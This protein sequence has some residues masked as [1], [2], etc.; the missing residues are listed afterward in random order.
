MG[1]W[2]ISHFTPSRAE[3]LVRKGLLCERT[4]AGEWELP[5]TEQVPTPPSGYVVSFAHFHE[6]GFAS[7]PSRF[8]RGLLH[9]YGLELQHLNP[10]GIQHIAAFVALCEGF[11]GIAPNF[12]L[13]KYFFTVS[14]YQKTEKRGS[15]QR[16][17]PV[18]IGCAG[19]HLRHTRSKEYM[20]MKT[21]ASHKGWHNQWFYVKNY[22]YSPLPGFT[23]RT[24]DVAPEVWAYGPVDKE[25]KRIFDLLQAIERLKRSGLTGAGVIGA[26]HARRVAPLMLRIRP[27]AAMTSDAPTEGTVLAAGALAASE[28]R[29]RIR[30]ALEDKDA[31][32]PIP[33][34]PPMRPDAGFIDL[35]TLTRVVD[36]LP[37]VPEDAERRTRNRLLAE[38]QKRRKDKET[39]KKRKKAA[40]E[41]QRRRRGPVVSDDDDDDDD[42]DEEDEDEEDDEE[43]LI[44]SFRSGALVIREVRPRTTAGGEA[45]EASA[46][47]PVPQ[48]PGVA[49]QGLARSAPQ[50][51]TR[52]TPQG[53]ARGASQ[54]PA[55]DAPQGPARGAPQGSSRGSS[56][57]PA[58]SRAPRESSEP[59]PA[60]S[61]EPALGAPQESSETTPAASQ[62]PALGAPQ[63]SAQGAPRGTAETA[64]AVAPET[65]GPRSGDKRPLPDV[66]GSASGSEAKR[67]RRPRVS[68]TAAPR[69]L[70][71]QLAPKKALTASSSSGGR[72]AAPPAASGEALGEAAVPSVE[73]APV[74]AADG[75]TA[76]SVAGGGAGPFPPSVPPV[77][78]T[79]QG[80]I[81]PGPQAGEVIDLDAD[82]AEDTTA[83]GG[84]TDAPA[85]V[86]GSAA[87]ATEEG[88]PAPAA[89]AKEAVA[90]E[91]GT[92]APIIPA[93]VAPAAEA[94]GPAGGTPAGAEEPP[95]VVAAEGEVAAGI[96]ILPL[97]SEAVPP[98]GDPAAA[99]VA[100]SVQAPG[101]S[102]NPAASG[103][104]VPT[105]TAAPGSAPASALAATVPRA[106]RGSVLRWASREDPPRHLF[107]LDD[108]A[109][110][111]K[112]Q[113]VQGGLA[114]A[115]A[116]LSSAM[117][118]LDNVVLPGSQALQECSRGKS[119]FLRLERGLWERFNAERQ[120]TRELSMQVAAAQGAIGD[121]QRREGAALE[122]VRRS[123]A[124]L[125]AVIDKARLDHE[126][127]Q[128]AAE[129]AR[130]DAEELAR[131]RG[132]HEALQKTVERVRRERLKAW[133]DRDAEKVK[134]EEAEK[135][136]ADLGAEVSHLWSQVQG[137]QTAVSQGADR[138]RELK[139]WADGE[140][141]KLRELL[142]AERGEHGALREAVR[143]VCDGFGVVPEEGSS[144]LPARVLEVRRRSREI[145][146]D[147]LHIGVRRAFGVFGS[148]YSGINFAG[149]SGGYAAGY[150]EAELD[151]IDA[152][153]FAP[154]E[155]LAKLLEDEA[156]PSA[157][158]PTS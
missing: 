30:E 106:W 66:P 119:D 4:A 47:A 92:S 143:V 103:V 57:E 26:Y 37:P 67:A 80:V 130:R 44:S 65:G 105:S 33:G 122:E 126:E 93:G 142:D 60:A 150:S 63:E 17:P 96:P 146:V 81:P 153:V 35:G 155:T 23:G 53:S 112:W 87:A 15:Q 54:E 14:L 78:P 128:A 91:A 97:A 22:S 94:E 133:Q 19:I 90:T 89:A 74:T 139:G 49:P 2:G 56:L 98:L 48:D 152:A 42:D 154:A 156:V 32:Y 84:G 5:G 52:D 113:A 36:S 148:H 43:E 109:E 134:K 39:A 77:A 145:A 72:T 76:A 86:A 88:V 137:L 61:Q 24:I 85:A 123:E 50:E 25:K 55:R 59:T 3:G 40:E 107:T 151:E 95:Q 108:A 12:S 131:L 157:D 70:V 41:F 147:A 125:Q 71:L 64:S 127:F 79:A 68:G 115:R 120:R 13:W 45:E 75:A 10:N 110:W 141:A 51:L 58:R 9:Y 136:A 46:R 100:T 158:P 116:A 111:H 21:S 38:A 18:P 62:E 28:I 83:T 11:L 101:P 31:E 135:V 99:S 121:L 16:S 104:M 118:A 27:L 73:A 69:G 34:H 1:S 117:G 6:R 140:L 7:P 144:S 124:K 82:E 20:A 149:M 29:Q 129:R 8:F 102:V 138:E 132:E 114:N